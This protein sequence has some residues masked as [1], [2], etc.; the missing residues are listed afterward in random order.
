MLAVD[1]WVTRVSRWATVIAAF[2]GAVMMVIAVVDVAG[3]SIF[4]FAI[5]MGTEFI[6]ELNVLLV[7]LA[8]A[9]VARERGH[10]RITVLESFMPAVV[11]RALKLAGYVL[12]IL[13]FSFTSYAALIYTMYGISVPLEKFGVWD[14]VRWPFILTVFIGC[15]LLVIMYM[16]LVAREIAAWSR[17]ESL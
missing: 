5:P 11:S 4:R 6:E 7:F 16:V 8:I 14:F 15:S 9:Y 3:H 17:S 13:V 12:G 10:I 2:S 1:T